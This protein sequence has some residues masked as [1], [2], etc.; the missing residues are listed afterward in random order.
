MANWL[1]QKQKSML[2]KVNR[3]SRVSVLFILNQHIFI[4]LAH[5]VKFSKGKN[6]MGKHTSDKNVWADFCAPTWSRYSYTYSAN[7]KS[8]QKGQYLVSCLLLFFKKRII[9]S[10]RC[11][12]IPF[13]NHIYGCIYMVHNHHIL[14]M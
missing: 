3:Y 12:L 11:T 9:R 6:R 1:L 14:N 8:K 13:H 10:L 4:S 2:T 7:L 5:T